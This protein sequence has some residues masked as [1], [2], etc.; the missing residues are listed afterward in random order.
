[1]LRPWL[2]L[3]IP[4][5]TGNSRRPANH[6]MLLAVTISGMLGSEYRD[7]F[8]IAAASLALKNDS[9]ELS[10]KKPPPDTREAVLVEQS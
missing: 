10:N 6:E 9:Q 7:T 8:D 3:R 2:F 1:M 5:L 4:Y